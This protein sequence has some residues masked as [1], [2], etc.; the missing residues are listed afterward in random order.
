MGKGRREPSVAHSSDEATD[1]GALT[2]HLD[3]SFVPKRESLRQTQS[4]HVTHD[5]TQ[6]NLDVVRFSRKLSP[7]VE[8]RRQVFLRNR[9]QHLGEYGAL[10]LFIFHHVIP[11]VDR[12]THFTDAHSSDEPRHERRV[13]RLRRHQ[14]A[15]LIKRHRRETILRSR[16][17]LLNLDSIDFL[18]LRVF[19]P[20]QKAFRNHSISM[21]HDEA[22]RLVAIRDRRLGLVQPSGERFRQVHATH[23]SIHDVDDLIQTILV[24]GGEIGPRGERGVHASARHALEHLCQTRA[25]SHEFCD[26]VRPQTEVSRFGG[27]LNFQTNTTQ[28]HTLRFQI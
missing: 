2:A 28:N 14:A 8:R 19:V 3:G 5:F 7:P 16:D 4:K 21:P 20:R 12:R 9:A 23:S 18:C 13:T 1:D 17:N 22:A 11:L 25:I 15:P 10:T 24:R 6:A 26:V 27:V